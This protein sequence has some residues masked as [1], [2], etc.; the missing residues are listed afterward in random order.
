MQR[1][2]LGCIPFRAADK[3]TLMPL[4]STRLIYYVGNRKFAVGFVITRT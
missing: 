4:G 1:E 3:R 2:I